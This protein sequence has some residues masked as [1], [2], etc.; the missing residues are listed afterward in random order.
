MRYSFH[1][2]AGIVQLVEKEYAKL[3]EKIF[4]RTSVPALL[5]YFMNQII[6]QLTTTLLSTI[7]LFILCRIQFGDTD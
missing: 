5:G 4:V 7:V 1:F 2:V 6:F 3:V